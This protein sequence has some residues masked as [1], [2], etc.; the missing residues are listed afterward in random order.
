M[1]DDD[2]KEGSLDGSNALC[3]CQNIGEQRQ[4]YNARTGRPPIR[5]T[6]A[7]MRSPLFSILP[8]GMPN[9]TF[10]SMPEGHGSESES[11]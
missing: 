9:R 8:S 1:Q 4:V 10:V 3:V 2:E 5:E 11:E 6:A 7:S